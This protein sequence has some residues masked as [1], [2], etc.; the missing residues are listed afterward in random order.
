MEFSNTG[1]TE[2]I[3]EAGCM[4]CTSKR[5]P[6]TK[7][8]FDVKHNRKRPYHPKTYQ[9][10]PDEFCPQLPKKVS[11]VLIFQTQGITR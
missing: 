3:K 11:D 6:S 1:I 10:Y 7:V 9:E 2:A 4:A 8:R 5:V